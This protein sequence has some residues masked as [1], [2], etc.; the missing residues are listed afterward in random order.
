MARRP[1][2]VRS[3]VDGQPAQAD[4]L[5]KVLYPQTG[6]TK[7]EVLAL[8]RR[9]R[10]RA[11]ARTLAGRPGRPASAGRT[12]SHGAGPFFEKNLPRRHPRLGGRAS[13]IAAH[14]PR[15]HPRTRSST[16]LATLIWLGQSRPSSSTCRSGGSDAR[17]RPLQPGPAGPRPRPRRPARAA[18]SAPTVALAVRE[19]PARDGL[20][21]AAGHQRHQGHP[22]VRALARRPGRATRSGRASELA[23]GLAQADHPDL[24]VWRMTKS[25]R[26]GQGLRRLEPEQRREDDHR[27]LLAAGA[28]PPVGGGA[29]DVGGGGG[30]RRAARSPGAAADGRGAAPGRPGRRPVRAAVARLSG[31]LCPAGP[32]T[33]VA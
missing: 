32:G 13:R 25:L 16:T 26:R 17:G 24:V 10:R 23:Q 7:A 20:P 4:N 33:D 8:L 12:A 1:R 5:D 19:R 18:T 21:R 14:R 31:C 27:A 2:S 15:H 29:A 22:A 6:T 3:S 9:P 30:R 11:A 28:G